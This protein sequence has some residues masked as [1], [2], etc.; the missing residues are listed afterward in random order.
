MTLSPKWMIIVQ[1]SITL[2]II[3]LNFLTGSFFSVI[4][5]TPWPCQRATDHPAPRASM[6]L[7]G[8]AALPLSCQALSCMAGIIRRH[9]AATGWLRRKLNPGQQA[10]LIL[11]CL[12]KGGTFARLAAGFKLGTATT[13]RYVDQ[14]G[15]E[16]R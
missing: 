14:H 10:L 5:I 4:S 1:P 7:F 13:W 2:L 12:H 9:R 16:T 6:S 15:A 8:R 3:L 11:A